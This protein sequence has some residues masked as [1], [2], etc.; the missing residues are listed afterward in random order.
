MTTTLTVRMD[1]SLKQ[2]FT[3]V[4][5]SVGLDAPTVVRMLAVQTVR[6]GAIP[7]S[8]AASPPSDE[9]MDFLDA[10]RADWGKW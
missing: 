9:T 1:E 10:A 5:E 7:L 6:D 8:L 3:A 2:R 4:V